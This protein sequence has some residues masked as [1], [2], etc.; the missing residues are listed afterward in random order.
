M[1]CLPPSVSTG[2]KLVLDFLELTELAWRDCYDDITSSRRKSPAGKPVDWVELIPERF[3]S[4]GCHAPLWGDA[5][6]RYIRDQSS[7]ASREVDRRCAGHEP[8]GPGRTAVPPLGQR[9][10]CP[11]RSAAGTGVPVHD[12]DRRSRDPHG[13]CR[14]QPSSGAGPIRQRARR[15]PA[16]RRASGDTHLRVAR[17]VVRRR[18][19]PDSGAARSAGARHCQGHSLRPRPWSL[20]QHPDGVPARRSVA[21]VRRARTTQAPHPGGRG[22]LASDGGGVPVCRAVAR[23]RARTS[24]DQRGT[25]RPAGQPSS[26]TRNRDPDV[27][28]HRSHRYHR[29]VSNLGLGRSVSITGALRPAWYATRR[30]GRTS[31]EGRGR[32][33]DARQRPR[34][35]SIGAP[36]ADV[37]GPPW[38]RSTGQ[39]ATTGRLVPDNETTGCWPCSHASSP[40]TRSAQH[41]LVDQLS[42]C[43]C[44]SCATGA[45]RRTLRRHFHQCTGCRK[46]LVSRRGGCIH[47]AGT[48]RTCCPSASRSRSGR[49]F[50]SIP[51][52]CCGSGSSPASSATLYRVPM[53]L[54]RDLASCFRPLGIARYRTSSQLRGIR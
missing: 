15:Q 54:L 31:Y 25:E 20:R 53:K 18:R 17:N 19:H 12:L 3:C 28:E 32:L 52:T 26:G 4:D 7:L 43:S 38:V 41:A 27:V 6:A 11:R 23:C 9:R 21:R 44:S 40:F 5:Q 10:S 14:C 39:L 51:R 2:P 33:H 30:V 24:R 49:D 13:L 48:P 46:A 45:S 29:P 50:H 22:S 37:D 1:D 16:L 36:I 47:E 42:G 34:R 8:T 35:P